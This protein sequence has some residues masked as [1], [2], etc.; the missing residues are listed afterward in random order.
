VSVIVFIQSIPI[1]HINIAHRDNLRSDIRKKS[2]R[3]TASERTTIKDR[4]RKLDSRLSTFHQKA[5]EFMG[6]IGDEDV[7]LL[8][9]L[10][11]VVVED[12]E[13]SGGEDGGDDVLEEE[14][15]N[16]E[17]EE[18]DDDDD[19]DEHEHPENTPICLPSPL[20]RDDI[21]K[22]GL[23]DLAAQ[24][25]ELR[26]GQANDSLMG[27]RM[28][29]GHKAVLYRTKVRTATS[30]IGKTRA[31][32]DIK[33]ATIKVN[34]HVRAYKRARKAM[35]RLGADDAMLGKYQE[36]EREHLKLSGD[37]TEEN[38][39]GQRNDVLPW[40]WRLEGQN[41]E[42]DNTWMQECKSYIHLNILILMLDKFIVLTG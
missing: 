39:F 24:E 14:N 35:E 9:Q 12:D 5:A 17:E 4:Q 26:Q 37:I 23:L 31:W 11:G 16:G 20:K 30:S 13:D 3:A 6:D 38:R 25:M 18:E 32:D 8:P 7:D 36:L 34:K 1:V 19:D 15:S 33:V 27:L 42:Q 41:A 21:Q 2:K 29:L 40:F 10:S 28:A 22:L